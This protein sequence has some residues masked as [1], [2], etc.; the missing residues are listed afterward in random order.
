[1]RRPDGERTGSRE[2]GGGGD[3][4]GGIRPDLAAVAVRPGGG[5]TVSRCRAEGAVQRARRAGGGYGHRRG[6]S[7]DQLRGDGA[8]WL[9]VWLAVGCALRAADWGAVQC[10]GGVGGRHRGGGGG[11]AW[12][13]GRAGGSGQVARGGVGVRGWADGCA[14]VVAARGGGDGRGHGGLPGAAGG[15][16]AAQGH[17]GR[18]C[19]A[20]AGHGLAD[21]GGGA[22]APAADGAGC[23]RSGGGGA[24][25]G[26]DGE[27]A[28]GLADASRYLRLSAGRAGW[29]DARGLAR[30]RDALELAVERG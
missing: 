3:G 2:G 5:P 14:G 12:A 8:S 10:G 20:A 18:A 6:R 29:R 4:G 16:L 7:R 25:A 27:L 9:A 13:H 21:S 17:G 30:C 15:R 1:M 26:G 22:A 28:V 24:E 11:T 19:G 23:G